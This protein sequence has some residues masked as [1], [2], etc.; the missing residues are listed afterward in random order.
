MDDCFVPIGVILKLLKE[1]Q[2]E[3]RH[4]ELDIGT[5]FIRDISAEIQSKILDHQVANLFTADPAKELSVPA[6]TGGE[7]EVK[8]F[9]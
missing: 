6:L 8:E 3:P 7:E 1:L 4:Q 5:N 2:D 9:D